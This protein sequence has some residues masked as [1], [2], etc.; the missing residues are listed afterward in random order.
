MF[1]VLYIQK[2]MFSSP[3]VKHW[4]I[5]YWII[6]TTCKVKKGIKKQTKQLQLSFFSSRARVTTHC[7]QS[8]SFSRFTFLSLSPNKAQSDKGQPASPHEPPCSWIN[9]GLLMWWENHI[10]FRPIGEMTVESATGLEVAEVCVSE[11]WN[12]ISFPVQSLTM[13]DVLS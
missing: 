2:H 6:Q 11:K 13:R 4:F 8:I 7:H 12:P 9:P 1:V 5:F 10:F 3:K